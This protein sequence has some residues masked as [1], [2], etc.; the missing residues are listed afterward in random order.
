MPNGFAGN[1][2]RAFLT[3]ASKAHLRVSDVIEENNKHTDEILGATPRNRATPIS[4][5]RLQ[6]LPFGPE[7]ADSGRHMVGHRNS[8]NIVANRDEYFAAAQAIRTVDETLGECIYA[9]VRDIE[10]MCG[11]IFILPSATPQFLDIACTIKDT[12][13]NFR[14]GSE[15]LAHECR[16]FATEITDIGM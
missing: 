14:D 15:S 5:L 8:T 11:T 1:G 9:A 16:L 4:R 13:G 3:S 12:L 7:D 2:A 6:R 10:D